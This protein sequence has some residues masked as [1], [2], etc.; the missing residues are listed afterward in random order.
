MC[1]ASSEDERRVPRQRGMSSVSSPRESQPGQNGAKAPLYAQSPISE[2]FPAPKMYSAPVSGRST[3]HFSNAPDGAPA[4]AGGSVDHLPAWA[5]GRP[6]PPKP[7]RTLTDT[8]AALQP[9]NEPAAVAHSA[10]LNADWQ[11]DDPLLAWSHDRVSMPARSSFARSSLPHVHPGS[12]SMTLD[13]YSGDIQKHDSHRARAASAFAS[14]AARNATPPHMMGN[15]A[16]LAQAR[17]VWGPASPSTDMLHG[18]RTPWSNLRPRSKLGASQYGRA[19]VAEADAR[20]ESAFLQ[21]Q[22]ENAET[23]A[24]IAL[25]NDDLPN[26]RSNSLTMSPT[27]MSG[28]APQADREH[29][30]PPFSLDSHSPTSQSADVELSRKMRSMTLPNHLPGDDSDGVREGMSASASGAMFMPNGNGTNSPLSSPLSGARGDARGAPYSSHPLTMTRHSLV[31]VGSVLDDLSPGVFQPYD[32][33]DAGPANFHGQDRRPSDSFFPHIQRAKGGS[34]F[35]TTPGTAP[36]TPGASFPFSSAAPQSPP[37]FAG[38]A[39]PQ[40]VMSPTHAG[41]APMHGKTPWGEQLA[42]PPASRMP[43]MRMPGGNNMGSPASRMLAPQRLVPRM[44][45]ARVDR[46]RN[47]T[48]A[49]P[50]RRANAGRP[51]RPPV[52]PMYDARNGAMPLMRA[53]PDESGRGLPIAPHDGMPANLASGNARFELHEVCGHM[54]EL[55]TDQYGSRLIQEKLDHCTPQERN[56]VFSELFPEA[57]R[58]MTDV[59]GNYV[60]QKLFEYGSKDQTRALATRLQGH[61]LPLSLGTYGCRVVQKAFEHV[62]EQQ[63]VELGQELRPYVLDC[64]RDQNA[65]HVIQKILEQLPAEHLTFISSAFSG[66]VPVLAS[67]CYS[68]RVLQRIFAYCNESQRRP[69]LDE[70]HHDTLRLMQDQY[71]NYVVQWVLQ[72]GAANDRA[73]IVDKTKGRLLRLARHKFASNVVEQVIEVASPSDRHELLNELLSPLDATE[74]SSLPALPTGPAVTCA[75]MVMMQDQYANY[76]LQRFLQVVQGDDRDRLVAEIRPVLGALRQIANP[77]QGASGTFAYGTGIR[78]PGGGHIGSKPLLAIERLIDQPNAPTERGTRGK[79][80]IRRMRSGPFLPNH[81]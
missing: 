66:H 50:A 43:F 9:H 70:M 56:M 52:H 27:D 4:L 17:D 68:C 10:M 67:H 60:I 26:E 32:A 42:F 36:A 46:T 14:A 22:Q 76:V 29:P 47:T 57:R 11:G 71:G 24:A 78:L 30:V 74:S 31:D 41:E 81:A 8:T 33:G 13:T 23:A 1:D 54:V 20:Q 38:N 58:L 34:A 3:P 73:A 72:H 75:A 19:D 35:S 18:E 77:A 28:S 7:K 25:G 69:L 51:A 65:N 44:D 53:V 59:F 5:A 6:R 21:Q 55:S 37:S 64:V 61:V 79:P 12:R 48:G 16:P 45:D 49:E 2:V 63:K 40:H 15:G 62:Q 39:T 80:P